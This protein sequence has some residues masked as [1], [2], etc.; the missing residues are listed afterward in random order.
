MPNT[1]DSAFDVQHLSLPA[2]LQKLVT[3]K[4]VEGSDLVHAALDPTL[5]ESTQAQSVSPHS[6]HALYPFTPWSPSDPYLF[7]DDVTFLL[8]TSGVNHDLVARAIQLWGRY[9]KRL[10]VFSDTA[11]E[12]IGT[13]VLENPRPEWPVS[14]ARAAPWKVSQI[15]RYVQ[16]NLNSPFYFLLDDLTFPLLDQIRTKLDHYRVAHGGDFPTFVAGKKTEED[17]KSTYWPTQQS[18]GE[19]VFKRKLVVVNSALVGFDAKFVHRLTPYTDVD[20]C[21][22]LGTDD[23]ALGGLVACSGGPLESSQFNFLILTN[24]SPREKQLEQGTNLKEWRRQDAYH[25]VKALPRLEESF[26]WYYRKTN[27]SRDS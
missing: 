19:A 4:A 17:F 9:I 23:L 22:L 2:N 11:D 27:F 10:A 13:I 16:E 1:V 7:G 21:P 24:F 26:E 14:D 25:S 12:Q 18:A 20:R 15:F 6:L 8:V 5:M 3:T